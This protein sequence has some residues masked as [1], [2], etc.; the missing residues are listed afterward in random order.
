MMRI[1]ENSPNLRTGLQ[2]E[3]PVP[4]ML[5]CL[6]FF[7][8]IQAKILCIRNGSTESWDCQH[9]T[10]K[11]L[12]QSSKSLVLDF[13]GLVWSL[14]PGF[15]SSSATFQFGFIGVSSGAIT[16]PFYKSIK[17]GNE[18]CRFSQSDV[19]ISISLFSDNWDTDS[20]SLSF[21]TV[22]GRWHSN[23]SL[24]HKLSLLP[25]CGKTAKNKQHR[26]MLLCILIAKNE[27]KG[28]G[29]PFC[30]WDIQNSP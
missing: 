11:W 5:Y 18:S 14:R 20:Q 12:N 2:K 8:C 1:P 6:Q 30:V 22:Q 3:N 28:D 21:N 19:N 25:H 29:A 4:Q 7:F 9:N 26:T 17:G 15:S 24:R 16:S 23:I 10:Y 13:E 27:T